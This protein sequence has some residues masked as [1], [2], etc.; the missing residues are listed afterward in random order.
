MSRSA[1]GK[2]GPEPILDDQRVTISHLRVYYM[3]IASVPNGMDRC[4]IGQRLITKVLRASQT[5]WPV[6]LREHWS[7]MT[8]ARRIQDLIAWDHVKLGPRENGR[9]T[10]YVLTSIAF[11]CKPKVEPAYRR[12]NKKTGNPALS[13]EMKRAASGTVDA[14]RATCEEILGVG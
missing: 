12:A 3:L 10:C 13:K 8:V 6:Q 11:Q 2:M 9:R 7:Q 1:F 5:N 14:L 4:W